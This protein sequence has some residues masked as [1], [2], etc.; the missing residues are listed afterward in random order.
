MTL[1]EEILHYWPNCIEAMVPYSNVL[2]TA[3]GNDATLKLHA[4]ALSII[5]INPHSAE[6]NMVIGNNIF[7]FIMN[8]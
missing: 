1:Y 7:A 6:A 2:Y 8:R 4:L 5:E 3:N